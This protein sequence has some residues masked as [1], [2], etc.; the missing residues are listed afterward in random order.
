ML[1]AATHITRY[2]AYVNALFIQPTEHCA[3]N[4]NGCYVKG[5][6]S[7]G[8][9]HRELIPNLVLEHVNVPNGTIRANQVTIALDKKPDDAAAY[10]S[11]AYSMQLVWHNALAVKDQWIGGELHFTAHTIGDFLSYV[12]PPPRLYESFPIYWDQLH[13][14]DMLSVSHLDASSVAMLQQLR[15][16]YKFGINWNLTVDPSVNLEKIKNSVEVIAPHVDTIYLVLHK[17]STGMKFDPETFI[18]HQNFLSYIKTLPEAIQKK[19]HVDGCI[20][21]SKKFL[22]TGYGC[23]SNVSRF[24]VWPD[25]SVTGCAYNQKRLTGRAGD[26]SEVL[27]NILTVSKLYEFDTC[28][29]PELIDSKHPAIV[30]K[31]HK[32]LEILT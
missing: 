9:G 8:E 19:V 5:F 29:I 10:N 17:P 4:C 11:A 32:Y 22:D 18:A 20:S 24:Q 25:G 23:S 15:E 2:Y 6:V 12:V 1:V 16:N 14:I 13:K 31:K 3:R 21:D 28:K 26:A 7:E 27:Q 30:A